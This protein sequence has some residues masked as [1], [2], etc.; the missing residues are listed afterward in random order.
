ML[1]LCRDPSRVQPREDILSR[2]RKIGGI[3]DFSPWQVE[4]S[5]KPNVDALVSEFLDG[6]IEELFLVTGPDQVADPVK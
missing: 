1:R 4:R 2:K 6:H 5:G 3:V